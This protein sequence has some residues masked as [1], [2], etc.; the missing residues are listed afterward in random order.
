[1]SVLQQTNSLHDSHIEAGEY[2]LVPYDPA[3]LDVRHFASA[4]TGLSTAATST[5][6]SATYTV[7]P[8]DSLWGIAR[9]HNV[10][11]S[12]LRRWNGRTS[13]DVLKH[14]EHLLVQPAPITTTGLD[15]GDRARP[16]AFKTVNY[17]VRNG[18][19]LYAIARRFSVTVANL[20]NW[21]KLGEDSFLQPGQAMTLYLDDAR[22]GDEGWSSAGHTRRAPFQIKSWRYKLK[23]RF[24]GRTNAAASKL[25]PGMLGYVTDTA[26]QSGKRR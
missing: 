15:I 7:Q 21:N 8:G 23:L 14:G 2:L 11:V 26:N 16:A 10:L 22:P 17:S 6:P 18:D 13:G 9:G 1:M 24:A 5:G 19:S 20:R 3:A 25:V 12:E 4:N